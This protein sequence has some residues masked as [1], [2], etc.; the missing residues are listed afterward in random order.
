MVSQ[1]DQAGG[2]VLTGLRAQALRLA[3]DLP[4]SLRRLSVR[5]NDAVIEVEWQDAG[6]VP[7]VP[8]PLVPVETDAGEPVDDTASIV[9]TSPMVGTV[10]HSPGPDEPPFVTVGDVVEPGQTVLIV[11]AMKLFNPIVSE[12]TAIVAEVLVGN[13]ES[14]EFGQPLLRLK[15][16]ADD[17]LGKADTD[18]H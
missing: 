17:E 15:T 7:V 4:G 1:Q 16:N 3:G 10:Y 2:D 5:S 11:E 9:V 13:G 8:V 6:A 12:T 14:V 18:V